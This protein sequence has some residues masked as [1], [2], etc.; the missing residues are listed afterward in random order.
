MYNIILVPL[1]GSKRSEMVLPHVESLARNYRAKIV[2]ITINEMMFSAGVVDAFSPMAFWE[3]NEETEK[4]AKAY[5]EGLT[6]EFHT[7]DIR[8]EY[9]LEYGRAVETILKIAS[10]VK[11][12]LV[13][14][15]SHGRGGMARVFYGS[16]ASGIVNRIDRPLLVIR[17]RNV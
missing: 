5:L 11:A 9:R 15:A 13:A 7:K 17:S 6:R 12:D 4:K 16:V 2:L 14:M 10:E 3:L 1:D 8:C